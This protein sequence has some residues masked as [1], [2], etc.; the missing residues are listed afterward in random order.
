MMKT[1]RKFQVLAL[2]TLALTAPSRATT[3]RQIEPIAGT[4][5][6][7]AGVADKLNRMDGLRSAENWRRST[8]AQESGPVGGALVG[9]QGR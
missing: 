5:I 1:I 8:L 9:A 4:R 6:W 3:V 7:C 2:L